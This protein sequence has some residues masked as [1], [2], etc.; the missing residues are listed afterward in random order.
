MKRKIVVTLLVFICFLLQSTVFHALAF[1][2]IVPNLMIVLTAS[3]GFMR[4]E[5]SGLL[6]GFFSG[7][8]IDI[9]FGS[10]WFLCPALHV[11][12]LHQWE[13]QPNFLSGGYQTSYGIDYC[14]RF[15]LWYHLLYLIVFNE[16][17]IQY[18]LLF[19]P[20]YPARNRLYHIYYHFPLSGN[21]QNKP[22]AGVE[23]TKEC[24]KVC[25]NN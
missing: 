24:K 12:R 7:F 1:G 4:G 3:F 8:F 15:V 20:Y 22:K 13:I 17:K 2:N 10:P 18:R 19:C 9:F 6:I 16:G 23:R 11:Y 5:K 25:L 21:T 14:Q